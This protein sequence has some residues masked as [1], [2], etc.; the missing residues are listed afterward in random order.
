[1]YLARR[2][3]CAEKANRCVKSAPPPAVVRL[4]ASAKTNSPVPD[5]RAQAHDHPPWAPVPGC[6]EVAP[7]LAPV[8]LL[9]G[10]AKED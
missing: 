4:F 6:R 3:L 5:T 1:M 7:S 10:A 9:L 2:F 8:P